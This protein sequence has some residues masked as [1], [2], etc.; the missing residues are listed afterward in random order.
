M[1]D[2]TTTLVALY[3]ADSFPIG[4]LSASLRGGTADTVVRIFAIRFSPRSTKL[5]EGL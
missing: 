1:A 4:I 2:I 3:D 5:S